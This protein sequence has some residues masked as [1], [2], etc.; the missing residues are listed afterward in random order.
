MRVIEYVRRSRRRPKGRVRQ[1]CHRDID[2]TETNIVEVAFD[3]SNEPVKLPV[4]ANL[5]SACE[6]RLVGAGG[7]QRSACK[8]TE[9][10]CGFFG[11]L[12]VERPARVE[13]DIK[14]RPA[15][16]RRG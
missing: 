8:F 3:T 12:I 11:E 4:V 2:V 15:K 13:T 1:T 10:T 7:K 5:A 6:S 9:T 14:S 16:D